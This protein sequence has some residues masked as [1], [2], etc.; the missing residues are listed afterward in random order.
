[1]SM[2]IR[3]IT[4]VAVVLGLAA[5]ATAQ[6]N[7]KET[8]YVGMCDASTAVG[9]GKDHFVVGDDEQSALYIYRIANPKHVAKVDLEGYLGVKKVD[10]NPEETDIE[11]SARIGNRI[12]WITSHGADG[13]GDPQP[14]RRQFFATT[15]VDGGSIP[16]VRPL[17]TKPYTKLLDKV[18]ADK[19]FEKVL[20]D[21]S[22]LA[23]E[24]ADGLGVEGLAPTPDGKGLL[25]GLRNPR[26]GGKA[27]ILPLVN[28]AQVV[29][30]D[31]DPTFRDLIPLDLGT[32][33]IRS[34]EWTGKDYLIVAGPH[35]DNKDLGFRL[36]RWD[37]DPNNSRPK[38]VEKQVFVG[39]NPEAIFKV[40]TGGRY[41][42]LSDDGDIPVDDKKCK[43]K[44]LPLEKKGFRG[45]FLE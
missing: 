7:G 9:I 17:K 1:M 27:L 4:L 22:K 23:P 24:S 25:I 35:D 13:K 12:Y 44:K 16:T 40:R 34:L 41:Y 15:V 20:G 42:V 31:A 28:P 37:G 21:A 38:L 19:R 8:R 43:S 32:R 26:P 11:G 2:S 45:A 39:I 18:I 5:N 10:G 14:D 6:S 29:E 36:Y 30:S 3:V 33:G